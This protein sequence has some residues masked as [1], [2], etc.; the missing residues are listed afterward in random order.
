M[1]VGGEGREI[2]KVIQEDENRDDEGLEDFD[3]IYS[4]KDVNAVGAEDGEGSHVDVVDPGYAQSLTVCLATKGTLSIPRL[5]S[6][7]PLK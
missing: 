3:A 6:S 5:T 1:W 4:G 7:W 2:E